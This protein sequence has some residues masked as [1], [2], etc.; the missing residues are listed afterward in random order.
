MKRFP[1]ACRDTWAFRRAASAA[2]SRGGSS[3]GLDERPQHRDEQGHQQRRR[4]AL[5]GDVAE[6]HHEAAVR[7][8]DDVEEVAANRI[9][10]TA[11]PHRLD[12]LGAMQ[13][14]RQHGQLNVPRDLEI[15]LEREPIGHFQQDEEIQKEEGGDN[16]LRAV[17]QPRAV[18]Q[19]EQPDQRQQQRADVK[20]P[21][22]R[23][24]LHRKRD[25]KQL[26]PPDEPA[27][28][29]KRGHIAEVDVA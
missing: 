6:R 19:P 4:A 12:G 8:R 24:E 28:P 9:R 14:V 1:G 10:G 29:G 21:S 11:D 2:T 13:A 27:V 18:G 16:R 15:V 17:R 3:H 5:A 23:R 26:R 7:Q 25:E 22:C 20:N